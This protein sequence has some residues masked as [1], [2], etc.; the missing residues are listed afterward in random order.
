[1]NLNYTASYG[2]VLLNMGKLQA[3]KALSTRIKAAARTPQEEHLAAEFARAV[4]SREDFPQENSYATRS[5]ASKESKGEIKSIEVQEPPAD[6]PSATSPGA[7][8]V[9]P[10]GTNAPRHVMLGP[11]YHL[12]GKVVAAECSAAGEVKLTLSINSVLMKFRA[13]DL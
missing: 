6:Q 9:P 4:A 12:E 13:A 5:P 2:F 1:G 11:E 7:T 3:A 8:P 10:P